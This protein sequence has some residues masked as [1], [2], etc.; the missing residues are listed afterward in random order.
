MDGKHRK[1]KLPSARNV[2]IAVGVLAIIWSV[3]STNET[4]EQM[5]KLSFQTLQ[6]AEAV[7]EEQKVRRVETDEQTAVFIKAT[8]IPDEIRNLPQ[9]DPVRR[10]WGQD[11][12]NEYVKAGQDANLK[13][14]E[15]AKEFR[16]HPRTQPKCVVGK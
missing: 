14:A 2:L 5:R 1:I 8:R 15:L 7:C 3:W 6:T 10:K 13:R 12:L 4:Q 9:D 11:L 16:E